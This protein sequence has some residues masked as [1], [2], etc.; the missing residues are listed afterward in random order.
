MFV[1]EVM[2]FSHCKM[3]SI[4]RNCFFIQRHFCVTVNDGAINLASMVELV[5]YSSNY[6]ESV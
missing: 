3:A 5:T 4:L 1:T 2:W 6:Y